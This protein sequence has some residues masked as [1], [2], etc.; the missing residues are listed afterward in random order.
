MFT[1]LTGRLTLMYLG[2]ALALLL[3][4]VAAGA[5]SELVEF[6]DNVNFAIRP[7]LAQSVA[8]M[9]QQL[10]AGHSL[11]DAATFTNQHLGRQGVRLTVL[12]DA[13][14]VVFSNVARQT[15]AENIASSALALVGTPVLEAPVPG[16]RVRFSGNTSRLVYWVE[17]D[18][19]RMVPSMLVAIVIAYFFARWIAAEATRPL[20]ELTRALHSLALGD[21]VPKPIVATGSSEINAL[22]GAYN[23]AALQVQKSVAE[24]EAAAENVRHFISD[25]GHELKTP[26]TIIMGYVDAVAEGVVADRSDADKILKKAL[27]ECRRMRVTIEKLLLLARLDRDAGDVRTIDVA[28]LTSEIVE[29]MKP[30]APGLHAELLTNGARAQVV[31]DEADLREALV[32]VIDNAVKYAPG[33][34]I[35]M[36][37]STRNDVVIIEIADAGPGMAEEDRERAFER[38]YRGSERGVVEGSGL[39]LA[40]AK[41]AAQRANGRITL[42]SE[43]GRGTSVKIYLPLLDDSK[44]SEEG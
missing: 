40:I 35:D 11:K 23:A 41:R 27:S 4:E 22:T 30:L 6:R 15:F 7:A 21:F 25:A 32:N 26:L 37:V 29:S 10:Q 20:R 24:R 5:W 12:D 16:G 2:A 43:V 3:I 31:G 36:R 9:N 14:Q 44:A 13:N 8:L 34:P 28:A 18:F 38:F 39:G 17:S 1:S 19:T 33:S 42:T